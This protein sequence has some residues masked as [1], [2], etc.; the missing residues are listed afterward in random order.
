[1]LEN[2]VDGVAHGFGFVSREPL[3]EQAGCTQTARHIRRQHRPAHR[4]VRFIAHSADL[5]KSPSTDLRS[6]CPFSFHDNKIK[7]AGAA[8]EPPNPR[9][10]SYSISFVL[11]VVE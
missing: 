5:L 2:T 4:A 6:I 10:A 1:M 8:C 9:F 11:G 7:W 3:P